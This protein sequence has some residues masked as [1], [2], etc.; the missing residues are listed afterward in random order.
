MPVT[1]SETTPTTPLA[2]PGSRSPPDSLVEEKQDDAA[3]AIEPAYATGLR[4]VI[5]IC[6]ICLSTLLTALDIGIVATAIPGIT[7]E[8]RRLNDVG[9]YGSACF[10]LVGTSAP[11]WGKI[12][13]FFSARLVYLASV[14]LF[15]VGSIVAA[16]APN[17]PALII[18]RALQGLGCSGT[19]GGSV[20][21]ISYVAEPKKRPMLIGLWMGIF[22]LST[23][24]GPVIGG[25]FTSDVT[26]RW[27][28]WINLPVGGL[29]IVLLLF[30]FHVPKHITPP[31]ATWKEILLQL[32]L[33][34]FGLLLSSLVCFTLALQWGGQTKPWNEG[35]VIA[36]LVMWVVLTIAF[37]VVEWLQG[38]YAM[39]PLSLLK[40][41][42]V[43]SNALYGYIQNLADFQIIFY[44]PIYFQS[45][46]GQS[47]ITSGVNSL[48]FMAFFAVG[49][50]LSGFLIGKTHLLQPYELI[51][52]LL[53]TA[54]AALLYT[55]DIGSS[56]AR[57]LGPQVLFGLGIGLGS[58]VP[59]TAAQSFSKPEDVAPI[60]GIMLMCNALSGAYFVTAA[61][62]IFA[63]RLLRTLANIAP[64]IDAA[65]VLATGASEI[66]HVFSG[67][68][69][70]AV[71]DAYMVGIKDIFAFSLAGAAFTVLISLV[72]P[73][74]KLPSHD[75]KNT[76]EE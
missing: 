49:T 50:M 10:L 29:I 3:A 68:E 17:S 15:L 36:T 43:W 9:W 47:A 59:M 57:Y 35:S 20:L 19:V 22:M 5:I 76:E 7:D 63:N 52:G 46:H 21:M 2:T 71:V 55:L 16:T 25:A 8:F 51:G 31:P 6:T 74:K 44:L 72:I 28:F 1:T 56:K 73:F 75:T 61:Q 23:V 38:A 12:Y 64:N 32:D 60:T 66:Q 33:L 69:L 48:P 53:A 45:I 42:M 54:G 39:V 14:A 4:L 11:V 70:T 40:P 34:G 62:S 67:D 18:A 65:K 13:K 27:C 26:W 37:L 24:I 58:Q 41:R 30:F